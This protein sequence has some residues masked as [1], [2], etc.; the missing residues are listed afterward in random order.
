[1]SHA[2]RVSDLDSCFFFF[3]DTATTEIYPLSLHDAL[4]ICAVRRRVAIFPGLTFPPRSMSS[5]VRQREGGAT[6]CI[7]MRAPRA[8]PSRLMPVMRGRPFRIDLLANTPTPEG[9]PAMAPA[10][11][12]PCVLLPNRT[13]SHVEPSSSTLWMAC[14]FRWLGPTGCRRSVTCVAV[15]ENCAE[16]TLSP[17]SVTATIC[18]GTGAVPLLKRNG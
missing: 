15:W 7:R 5:F 4:P 18:G 3:N 2:L 9:Q 17:L 16:S 11:T 8:T 1:M 10:T 13:P 14:T 6:S 12:L